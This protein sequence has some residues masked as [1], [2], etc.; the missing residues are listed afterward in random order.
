MSTDFYGVPLS[1]TDQSRIL[2]ARKWLRRAAISVLVVLSVLGTLAFYRSYLDPPSIDVEA[3]AQRTNNEHD[4]IGGFAAEFVGLWLT[5]TADDAAAITEYVDTRTAGPPT[6]HKTA[7]ASQAAT[8]PVA[9]IYTG[10]VGQVDMFSATVTALERQIP[11]AAPRRSYYRVPV[12]VWRQQTKIMGWPVPVN[13]PGPGVHVKPGFPVTVEQ[14][15]PLYRLVSDFVSTYLTKTTGLDRY[16]VAGADIWPV[17][18][19]S[20]AGLTSLRLAGDPPEKPAPG[21]AI[22][23]LAGVQAKTSQQ[24]PLPM[25][26]PLTL[27]NNNGTWMISALDLTPTLSTDPPEP[28]NLDK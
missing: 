20:S 12:S 23:A 24:V 7:A 28:I 16:V 2:T 5:A 19:Y 8:R 4:Q 26:M 10:T 15:A 9:V 22:A 11:S 27:E 13:G 1:R 18:G 3:I 14:G 25:T 21:Q 17:G 6:A